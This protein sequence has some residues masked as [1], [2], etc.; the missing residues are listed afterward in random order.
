MVPLEMRR[1]L[2]SAKQEAVGPGRKDENETGRYAEGR[3]VPRCENGDEISRE[4]KRLCGGRHVADEIGAEA[5]TFVRLKIAAMDDGGRRN[6]R[7]YE[8][9]HESND[10]FL[11]PEEVERDDCGDDVCRELSRVDLMEQDF[12]LECHVSIVA[13]G[14]EVGSWC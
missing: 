9:R 6:G 11:L 7:R 3:V 2:L 1:I 4:A 8:M 5:G 10:E 13:W 12:F 14:R